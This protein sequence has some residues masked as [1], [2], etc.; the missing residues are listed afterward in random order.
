ME[1][2]IFL[3]ENFQKKKRRHR[4][5]SFKKMDNEVDDEDSFDGESFGH[6]ADLEKGKFRDQNEE[7]SGPSKTNIAFWLIFWLLNNVVLTL[8]KLTEFTSV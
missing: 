4:S 8:H 2:V 7:D 5:V 3:K 1:L 6:I